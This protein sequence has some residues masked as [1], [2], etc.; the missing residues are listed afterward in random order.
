VTGASGGIGLELA[1]VLAREGFDLVL[2]AR[3]KDE[4]E[5]LAKAIEKEHSISTTVIAKDL[6]D[7]AAPVALFKE[8]KDT[9]ID[10]LVNNAG[11]G[12]FGKFWEI[13]GD[14]D[15]QQVQLNVTALT[16]LTRLF[17]KPMVERKRGRILNVAS[18]AGFQ[19]GPLMAVYYA[20]KAFV[21]SFSEA[22]AVELQGTGVTVTALCPGP[23]ESGFQ[24]AASMQESGLFKSL[25]VADSKSV[26]EAGVAGMLKGTVIVVP[27]L[28]NKI[29]IQANR[30]APRAIVRKVV[31]RMQDKR[32]GH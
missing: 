6:G 14:R 13:E 26:A 3:R 23:T 12:A 4:L 10:V 2:V 19:P 20:T 31:K 27:G 7:P 11:F 28:M 25:P 1:K 5:K 24:Q 32:K 9:P 30:F 21:L 18:T 8:L 29:G 15:I 16:H 22:I 17:L